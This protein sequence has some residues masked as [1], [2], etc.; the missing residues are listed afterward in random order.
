MITK[1]LKVCFASDHVGYELKQKLI[2]Y[3][4]YIEDEMGLTV[5]DYG[6]DS[7]APVDYPDFAKKLLTGIGSDA[8]DFGILICGSGIGMSI[9][10]NRNKSAR[11]ALC[12]NTEL[13]K[14]AR[15]HNDAN[16]LV[17]G[18]RFTSFEDSK[19]MVKVFLTAKFQG[20][21]HLIRVQKI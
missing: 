6:T 16:I 10:T 5:I 11:A 14:L 21:R 3:I 2:T 9:Y 7:K 1:R 17:L 20:G 4:D 18:A 13:V 15:E 12:Y 19:E 8:I